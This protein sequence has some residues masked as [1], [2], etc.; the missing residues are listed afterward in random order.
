VAVLEERR[1]PLRGKISAGP[2]LIDIA[3]AADRLG[4]IWQL[5][6]RPAR[7]KPA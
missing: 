7:M 3:R 5:L 2:T 6:D 1:D 4:I